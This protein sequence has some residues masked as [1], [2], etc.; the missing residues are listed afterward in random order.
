MMPLFHVFDAAFA[1]TI[2]HGQLTLFMPFSPRFFAIRRCHQLFTPPPLRR[3]PPFSTYTLIIDYFPFFAIRIA[4]FRWLSILPLLLP[5]F[6]PPLFDTPC[7]LILRHIS[8]HATPPRHD[9]F[10]H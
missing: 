7:W 5:A 3:R 6:C 2:R 10:R 9:E 4:V 8:P 1:A